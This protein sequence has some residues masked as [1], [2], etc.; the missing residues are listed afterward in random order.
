[1]HNLISGIGDPRSPA[2]Q[3]ADENGMLYDSSMGGAAY[4]A[5][6]LVGGK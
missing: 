3:F 6:R 2:Q 4:G 5:T 1:M